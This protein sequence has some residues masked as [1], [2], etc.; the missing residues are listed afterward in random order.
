MKFF[1]ED[2]KQV[3]K[4]YFGVR[5]CTICNDELQDVNLVELNSSFNIFFIPVKKL[6]SKHILVCQNC[7]VFMEINEELWKYYLSYLNKRFNKSTTDEIIQMLTDINEQLITNGVK[8][9]LDNKDAQQSIDLIYR[10]MVEKYKV[11]ENVEEL[12]SVFYK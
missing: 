8:L 4:G 11:C 1:G 5:R 12:I 6:A 2:I 10:S 7:G 3:D 9:E